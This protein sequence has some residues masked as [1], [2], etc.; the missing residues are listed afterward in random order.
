MQEYFSNSLEP[1]EVFCNNSKM[2]QV[3]RLSALDKLYNNMLVLQ[4]KRY[5]HDEGI[6][7]KNTKEVQAPFHLTIRKEQ[8]VNMDRDWDYSL[9]GFI[10][11]VGDNLNSGHYITYI[12]KEGKW[13]CYDDDH[14]YILS[15]TDAKDKAEKAYLF[16]YQL[17]Q[18]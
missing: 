6:S 14:V 8:T 10:C 7:R 13:I 11:H 3:K 15:D 17:I 9:A 4:L 1:D 18:A 2:S 12:R 5:T 16:F